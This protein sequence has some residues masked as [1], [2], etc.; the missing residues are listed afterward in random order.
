MLKSLRIE[1][2]KA[3]GAPQE[4]PLAPITLIYGPN[5]AGKSSIIQSL[6]LMKQTFQ[7]RPANRLVF[8]GD[9]VD[10]GTYLSA[11]H[12]HDSTFKMKLG[13]SFSPA[14]TDG[15]IGSSILNPGSI[16]GIDITIDLPPAAKRDKKN[17]PCISDV[18]YAIGDGK[19]FRAR[20]SR[21]TKKT[22][23]SEAIDDETD[24]VYK[25]LDED[26]VKSICQLIEAVRMPSRRSPSL[27]KASRLSKASLDKQKINYDLMSLLRNAEFSAIGLLPARIEMAADSEETLNGFRALPYE[28]VR[29][30]AGFLSPL[31]ILRK[32]FIEEI[33]SL[34]Y[35]GPLRSHP[36]R[37]HIASGSDRES[38]GTRGERTPQLLYRKKKEFVPKVNEIFQR[39]NIPYSLDV[40]SAGDSVTGEIIS[41]VLEDAHG[42]TVSPSDVGFGIGQLL[43][44]LVEGTVSEGR[45]ICVEQPEIHLHPRLQ[46]HIADF[47]I[48]TAKKNASPP[49]RSGGVRQYGGNQWIIETHSEAIALRVQRRIKEGLPPDFVSVL[50][51]EPFSKGGSRVM[52]LRLDSDGSFIDEWPDGFFEESYREIYG[53]S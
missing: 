28:Y 20:L 30:V 34:S 14:A 38:V 52:K 2:F 48:Q 7:N 44:I 3:F 53:A 45:L 15:T 5:S 32:E 36:A 40:R 16:R 41:V 26:S 18:T 46:G 13:F 50:Y 39:F 9:I 35:L 22:S 1:N 19:L 4:I 12:R 49:N 29:F 6:L 10:L 31:E 37:H 8:S 43:P 17:S 11:L 21:E 25:I 47:L 33:G 51:V 24:D 23:K 27:S 42:T